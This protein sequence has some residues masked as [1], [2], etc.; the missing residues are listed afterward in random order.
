MRESL[1]A[2]AFSGAQLTA[3]APLFAHSSWAERPFHLLARP[4]TCPGLSPFSPRTVCLRV[5]LPGCMHASSKHR[6]ARSQESRRR[7]ILLDGAMGVSRVHRR[8]LLRISPAVLLLMFSPMPCIPLCL[9]PLKLLSPPRLALPNDRLSRLPQ[10]ELRLGREPSLEHHI[11]AIRM[12]ASL[13]NL[14]IVFI[15]T[16]DSKLAERAAALC[17]EV[18]LVALHLLNRQ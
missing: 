1:R 7:S 3:R 10:D 5:Y 16:D 13:Y 9:F 12:I 4:V 17:P 6:P 15:A 14:T 2:N 11:E 8:S 18:Q